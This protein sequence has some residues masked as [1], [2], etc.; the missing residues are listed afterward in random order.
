MGLGA[1]S[2]WKDIL[3]IC[4][5]EYMPQRCKTLAKEL[6]RRVKGDKGLKPWAQG[7]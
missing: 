7:G 2:K 3:G 6:N 5:L 4:N 1:P